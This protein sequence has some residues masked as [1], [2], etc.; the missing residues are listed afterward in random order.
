MP[1]KFKSRDELTPDERSVLGG[2]LNRMV[3]RFDTGGPEEANTG[4]YI[5]AN[6]QVKFVIDTMDR[7]GSEHR[8]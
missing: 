6:K 7:Y 1:Y 2:Y 8:V 5:I 3:R 4:Y